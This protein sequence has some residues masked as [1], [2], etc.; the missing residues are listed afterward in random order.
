[1]QASGEDN[2]VVETQVL[3][4][5]RSRRLPEAFALMREHGVDPNAHSFVDMPLLHALAN[6]NVLFDVSA[7]LREEFG[8]DPELLNEEEHTPLSIILSR[9]TNAKTLARFG[10]LA[11][12]VRVVGGRL[13]APHTLRALVRHRWYFRSV[14]KDPLLREGFDIARCVPMMH[15]WH[16]YGRYIQY[17]QELLDR[18]PEHQSPLERDD[19]GRTLF[20]LEDVRAEML[21]L[22]HDAIEEPQPRDLAVAMALHPRLGAGSPLRLLDGELLRAFV[23]PFAVRRRNIAETRQRR[24]DALIAAEGLTDI[25]GMMEYEYVNRG[26]MF[27]PMLFRRSHFM[28]SNREALPTEDDEDDYLS[29]SRLERRGIVFDVPFTPAYNARALAAVTRPLPFEHDWGVTDL[30]FGAAPQDAPLIFDED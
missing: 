25:H 20:E 21:E 11:G 9:H 14:D 6:F 10:G 15:L 7:V 17:A 8:A 26:E 18:Y 24:L 13:D 16:R 3:H 22:L 29:R 1:M 30:R 28:W 12:L 2:G 19:Q 5:F 27:V 23:L 4:A